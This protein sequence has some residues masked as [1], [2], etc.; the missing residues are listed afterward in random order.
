MATIALLGALSFGKESKF[1][2]NL[3]PSLNTFPTTQIRFQSIRKNTSFSIKKTE[4]D[5]NFKVNCFV[6][7]SKEF[8]KTEENEERKKNPFDDI[9]QVLTKFVLENIIQKIAIDVV[10]LGLLITCNPHSALGASGGRI[11][12]SNF[13]SDSSSSYS[14]SY[15]SS[16]SSY[17]ST[18]FSST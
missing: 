4:V 2:G 11:G 15:S 10:I 7:P 16:S 8:E 18:S 14:S 1:F 12:G 6:K 17:S 5:R 3:N 13:S 9:I